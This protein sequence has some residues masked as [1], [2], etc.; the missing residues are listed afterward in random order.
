MIV[1]IIA[2]TVGVLVLLWIIV[3]AKREIHEK[4]INK[5]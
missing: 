5:K 3:Q 4:G 2:G 1:Q